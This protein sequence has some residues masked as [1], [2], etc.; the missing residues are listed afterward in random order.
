MSDANLWNVTC[1][2][3]QFPGMWQRWFRHQSVAVGWPPAVGF[4][5]EGKTEGGK[6][7]SQARNAIKQ[8]EAGDWV[9]VA[10]QGRRVGRIGQVTAKAIA[11]KEWNPLVPAGPDMPNGEMG[12]RILVRWDLTCG[13]DD[14][15][16]VVQLPDDFTLKP[17]ERRPVVSRLGSRTLEEFRKVMTDP[18]NWVGLLGRFGYE[19]ALSDYIALYPHHL[20]DGLLPHP[21]KKIREKVFENRSRAD[22]LLIDRNGSPVIV[23]CKQDSPTVAAIEQLRKYI[24]CLEDETGRTARGIL[25]H[26]GARNL[27]PDV[28]S[29]AQEQPAVKMVQYRLEVNFAP[30]S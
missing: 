29:K 24:R 18:S 28:R 14:L 7:W 8:I 11:D 23:E 21:N 25:V 19:K 27:R 30:S 26:G 3:D 4:R 5:L 15:D 6:G 1:M 22:V 12:R 10:L 13:P 17:A 20:E 9:V 16:S 2:E